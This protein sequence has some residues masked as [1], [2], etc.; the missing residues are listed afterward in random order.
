MIIA[1]SIACLYSATAVAAGTAQYRNLEDQEGDGDDDEEWTGE[2]NGEWTAGD[3]ADYECGDNCNDDGS[4][5]SQQTSMWL[6]DENIDGLTA[7]Q[8]ITYVSVGLLSFMTLMCCVCYPEILVV[9]CSKMCGCCGFGGVE[10][11]REKAAHGVSVDG[12]EGDNYVGGRQD[13]GKKKKRR[14]SKSRSRS[15]QGSRNRDRDVELV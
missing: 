14:K 1:I 6:D 3:D 12:M 8:I 4:G 7:E 15:R 9:G 10:K 11:A 13:S 2:W 5:A